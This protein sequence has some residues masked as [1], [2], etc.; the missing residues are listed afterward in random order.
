MN[1]E[2]N[3]EVKHQ[4]EPDLNVDWFLS[5]LV[6]NINVSGGGYGITLYC[7][8]LIITGELISGKEY[9]E[10]LS[11]KFASEEH[12]AE[13]LFI[14]EKEQYD[15]FD[16]DSCSSTIFIHLKEARVMHI[17]GKSMPTNGCLW[18]GQLSHVTGFNF[19]TLVAETA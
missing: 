13:T 1:I 8:G 2:E 17:N 14:E 11:Q 5:N 4:P 3:Q 6:A 16:A 7:N 19:G 18:R 10:S 15:N 9:F 12:P